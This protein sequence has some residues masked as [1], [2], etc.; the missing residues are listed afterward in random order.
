MTEINLEKTPK[1]ESFFSLR[2]VLAILLILSVS[3][4]FFGLGLGAARI[5][6]G[7]ES[8]ESQLTSAALPQTEEKVLDYSQAGGN[9]SFIFDEVSP[10]VVS[11]RNTLILRDFLFNNVQRT[12]QGSGVIIEETP[13]VY[14]IITNY[15]VVQNAAQTTVIFNEHTEAEAFMVGQDE[16]SDI[17]ILSV[18]KNLIPQEMMSQIKVATLGDSELLRVGERIL[19][20]GSPLGFKNTVTDGI[21]SGLQRSLSFADRRLSLIQTNAAINPGNSGGALVNMRGEVIGIN[22]AKIAGTQVEGLA[23]AIPINQVKQVYAEIMEKGYVSRPFLGIIGSDLSREAASTYEFELGVLVRGVIENSAASEAG[24]R[25]GDVIISFGG[26][27]I[28]Q[29][30]EL[31]SAIM[32]TKVGETL[33][34]VIVREGKERLELS[35]TMKERE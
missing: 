33:S 10:S 7:N 27:R 9:I 30:E 17:A 1:K 25:E 28:T 34:V 16:D 11:I 13:E 4:F 35:V 14:Y 18:S 29:M 32:E 3:A 20:I 21:I 6:W 8:Q 26:N 2:N 24:I 15:H 23:F 31:I 22:T 19:A 12:S 5:F